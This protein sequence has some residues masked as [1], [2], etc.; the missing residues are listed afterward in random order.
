MLNRSTCPF[1]CQ[2]G[3]DDAP[4]LMLPF[5]QVDGR[6]NE[7]LQDEE[8][9]DVDEVVDVVQLLLVADVVVQEDEPYFAAFSLCFLLAMCS[10]H[11]SLDVK[12]F[13]HSSQ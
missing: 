13:Q 2:E 11:A 7:E 8:L 9:Q 4:V 5:I 12:G 1:V 6:A 3:E 10:S